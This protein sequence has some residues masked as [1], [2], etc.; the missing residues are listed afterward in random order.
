MTKKPFAVY[1]AIG[2]ALGGG[3]GVALHNIPVGAG[4]GIAFG[5]VVG[6]LKTRKQS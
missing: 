1:V 2:I 6:L 4:L 5:V 3:L